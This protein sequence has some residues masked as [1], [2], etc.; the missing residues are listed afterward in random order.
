MGSRQRD[1]A[2]GRRRANDQEYIKLKKKKNPNEMIKIVPEGLGAK[3]WRPS[4]LLGHSCLEVRAGVGG[5]G[6]GVGARG[7]QSRPGGKS[8]VGIPEWGGRS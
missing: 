1:R 3:R 2:F 8:R 7:C 4:R 6:S 5:G